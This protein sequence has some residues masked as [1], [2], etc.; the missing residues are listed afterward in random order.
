MKSP[1]PSGSKHAPP[2]ARNDPCGIRQSWRI[3]L[4]FCL[5]AIAILAVCGTTAPAASISL[6]PS[7]DN[8]IFSE[9]DNSNA[10]GSLFAGETVDQKFRRAIFE[11]V[12]AGKIPAGSI[13]NSVTLSLTQ[14]KIGPAG[15]AAF[16]LHPVTA[17]WGQGTS[18][19][20][21][22]GGAPTA[23][24]A[25]WNYR[26]YNTSAWS[27]PGGDF[28]PMSGTT[29]IGLSDSVYTFSSQPGMVAD[30]QHWLD[31]PASNFGWVLKAAD[32]TLG[33]V[34]AREF[35]SLENGFP[36]QPTLTVN[37]TVPEPGIVA[38]LGLGTALLIGF[39]RDR[40]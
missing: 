2:A 19:G 34:T 38:L 7:Q 31:N 13:V 29:T 5:G 23:G 9:N 24:D 3:R 14:T 4:S 6:V 15:V 25:T 39:R 27:T 40:S 17:A 10:L 36:V 37:Y 1:S 22:M 11:F 30:V 20:S 33:V 28:G 26:F 12:L 32:E 16:E 21:G 8:T 35:G 18:I